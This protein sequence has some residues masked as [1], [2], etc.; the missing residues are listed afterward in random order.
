MMQHGQLVSGFN[1]RG[2]QNVSVYPAFLAP[3][4]LN[5]THLWCDDVIVVMLEDV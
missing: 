5:Q 1:W 3:S 2:I 4:E